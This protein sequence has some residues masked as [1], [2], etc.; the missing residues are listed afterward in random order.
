M[1]ARR[2][3]VV[4]PLGRWAEDRGSGLILADHESSIQFDHVLERDMRV[5]DRQRGAVRVGG[6]FACCRNRKRYLEPGSQ[7]MWCVHTRLS[8][9]A[10][11]SRIGIRAE[12]RRASAQ[13]K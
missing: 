2:V 4:T 13:E 1:V 10:L 7:I 8:I 6:R 5:L 3:M 11:G 12:Q 9:F